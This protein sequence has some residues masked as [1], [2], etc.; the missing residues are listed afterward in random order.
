MNHVISKQQLFLLFIS[1]V[2]G[3]SILMA[4]GLTATFAK[5][6]AWVSTIIASVIG[7][8]LNLLLMWLMK[9]Y[10]Y[11]SI[12]EITEK[13]LGKVMSYLVNGLIIFYALSLAAY[14]VRNLSNFMTT[15]ISPESSPANF[16]VLILL[17]AMYSV[18]FGLNNLA[19]VNE[20]FT[21]ITLFL[22]AASLVLV[23]NQVEFS[24]LKPFFARGVMPVL[25]GAYTILGF[26]FIEI[27]IMS[28]FFTYVSN[29][30]GLGRTYLAAML[31]GGA[32]LA[33]TVLMS[34]A[35]QGYDLVIRQTYSTFELMRDITIVRLFERV[36]VLIGVFWIFGIFVKITCCMQAAV[37][38]F[39]A[40]TKHTTYRPFI[41]P[42]ALF[43]WIMA[44][45]VHLNIVDFNNFVL[46]Y[47]TLWW[48]AL[49]VLFVLFLAA[50]L[51]LGKHKSFH[52]NS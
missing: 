38:G 12:F 28:S 13:I 7:L 41:I 9:K 48:F 46:K 26:P 14:I 17:V 24:N 3:S 33:L 34:L 47:W 31:I 44:N 20:F 18:F 40:M 29:K 30:K 32:V 51:L 10:H 5:N 6:E 52:K 36:E 42:A 25:H 8:I 39:K 35:I 4:P 15:S 11:A 45:Q 37:L 16:Q 50:G 21:P 23:L 1:F 19:R 27:I 43:V 22:L 49:Y 2:T